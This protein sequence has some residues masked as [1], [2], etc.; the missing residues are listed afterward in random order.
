MYQTVV[1]RVQGKIVLGGTGDAATCDLEAALHGEG[2][3][4][5]HVESMKS[6]GQ[7]DLAVVSTEL[8]LSRSYVLEEWT[9]T[10][11]TRRSR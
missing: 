5:A 4:V 8:L 1:N 2:H 6:Q 7:T 9:L 3:P 11:W 10:C